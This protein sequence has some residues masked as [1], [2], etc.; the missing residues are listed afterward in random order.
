MFYRFNELGIYD[1]P[2]EIDYVL[3]KT[4]YSQLTY[5]GHSMGT[6][7]FWVL[8]SSRPEYNAKIKQM[9][10]LSP[11]AFMRNVKS[12]IRLLTPFAPITGVYDLIFLS[13]C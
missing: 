10:A 5:I 9:H 12:P 7:M 3:K 13:F 8:A 6:T 1:L 4:G 2:A 11:V